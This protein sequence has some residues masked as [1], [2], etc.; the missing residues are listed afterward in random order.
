MADHRAPAER[1]PT[2]GRYGT[3]GR[4]PD[5]RSFVRFER[6]LPQSVD[7]IWAAISEPDQLAAWFP[8]LRFEAREGGTFEIRF[9][10]EC[11]GAAHVT[12]RVMAYEPPTLLQLGTMRWELTALPGGGCRL[13][14]TDLLVFEGPR[15]EKEITHSVL[16]GWHRYLDMLEDAAAGRVVDA[17][18]P[19]PDYARVDERSSA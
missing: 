6:H 14:F 17:H 19:E 11:D 16:G 12:G 2:A 13:V 8:G 10:G 5:G 4:A 1:R 3:V 18:R 9:D 15:S 7:R